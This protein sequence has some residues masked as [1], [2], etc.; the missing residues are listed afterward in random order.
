MILRRRPVDI[1]RSGLWMSLSKAFIDTD[2]LIYAMEL[3]PEF[4]L[5]SNRIMYMVDRGDVRGVVSSLVLLEVC[6]YLEARSRL[7]ALERI[8]YVL[9]GSRLEL[10]DVTVG[11]ISGAALLKQDYREI[12]LNDLVNYCAMKRLGV[13]KIYT[14]DRHFD[15]LPGVNPEF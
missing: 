1:I 2:V 3:H 5:R 4:G 9:E 13:E 14:N 10:V 11:D 15:Q 6:W 8:I 12:D 7:D